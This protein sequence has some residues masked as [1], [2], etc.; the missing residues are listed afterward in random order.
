MLKI[1]KERKTLETSTLVSTELSKRERQRRWILGLPVEALTEK[2]NLRIAILKSPFYIL[3][4]VLP[5]YLRGKINQIGTTK[6][7]SRDDDKGKHLV[8][9]SRVATG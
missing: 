8:V 2:S 4:S 6:K 7:S 5:I 1:V 3:L 9:D